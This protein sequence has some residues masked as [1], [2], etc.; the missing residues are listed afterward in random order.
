MATTIGMGDYVYE[1]RPDWAKLPAGVNFEAPSGVAVDSHDR[2]YVFQR[3][4]PPV[5]VFDREGHF[6]TRWTRRDGMPA[7]AHHINVG[8]GDVVYLVDRDAHQIL[9]YTTEGELVS[10]IG[11]RDRASLQKPFNHPADI[12]VAPSGE[13][14][15]AD[16]YG[17]SCIHRFS[18]RRSL[19]KLFRQSGPR[20]GAISGAPQHPGRQ[21]RPVVRGRP[22]EQPGPGVFRRRGVFGPMDRFQVPHGGPH[23]RE[24]DRLRY[25]P[26][27]QN[28]HIGLGRQFASQGTHLRKRPSGL[29]RLE[30]RHLW[31]GH[32]P[33]KDPEVRSGE[34]T[35]RRGPSLCACEV[36]VQG[37]NSQ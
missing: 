34:L 9:K 6:L 28:Q 8:P 19:H 21:R 12:C 25:R 33:P 15:V 26:D 14:Y 18:R 29:Y 16:G 31:G 37:M 7:D 36:M 30:R 17:N 22:R 20:A 35:E 1:Y 24:S 5:L 13:M 3:Q 2:V 4:G 11:E 27:S 32:S 10:S 23:R